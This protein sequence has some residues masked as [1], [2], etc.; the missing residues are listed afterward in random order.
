MKNSKIQ[1][2]ATICIVAFSLLIASACVKKKNNE[3]ELITTVKLH[4]QQKGFVGVDTYVWRDKDGPGGSDPDRTDT[5]YLDSGR[6][7]VV[8]AFFLNESGSSPV[9]I[10]SE[11]KAEGAEHRVCMETGT[12]GIID[13][14]ITD[15]DGKYPIGLE[16]EWNTLL[17][18]KSQL[19]VNLRH[20]PDSKDGTCNPGESDVDVTFPLWVR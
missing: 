3:E 2:H 16:S 20:Q 17:R 12:A 9:D 10:T 11:I 18:K 14:N 5:V 8:T 15:T 13:F 4:V 19:R 6:I 1:L 7:Y